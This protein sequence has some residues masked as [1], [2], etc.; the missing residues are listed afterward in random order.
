MRR[1]GAKRRTRTSYLE[2]PA[3]AAGSPVTRSGKVSVAAKLLQLLAG[4]KDVIEKLEATSLMY[5][6]TLT[7]TALY[8]ILRS[9]SAEGRLHHSHPPS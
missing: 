2:M 3:Q 8:Q 1:T 6:A 9:L 5:A 7:K 4:G